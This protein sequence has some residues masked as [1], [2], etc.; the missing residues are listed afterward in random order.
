L[1]DQH[2]GE[3]V[4]LGRTRERGARAESE[5]RAG[6]GVGGGVV[7]ADELV[8]AALRVAAPPPRTS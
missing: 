3:A 1:L 6:D 2:V 4:A 5:Q 7:P 8:E